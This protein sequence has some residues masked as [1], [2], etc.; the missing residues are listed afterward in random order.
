DK[1]SADMTAPQKE[2]LYVRSEQMLQAYEGFCRTTPGYLN[3]S[4]HPEQS[5][6]GRENILKR[7]L[8][9]RTSQ[10]ELLQAK[11]QRIGCSRKEWQN[12]LSSEGMEGDKGLWKTSK[13]SKASGR[14]QTMA[15]ILAEYIL[16]SP[17]VFHLR[18]SFSIEK[19]LSVIL[20]LLRRRGSRIILDICVMILYF[21]K[22]PGRFYGSGLLAYIVQ[23]QRAIS[24]LL[25]HL[26]H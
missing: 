1:L 23:G 19:G 24:S 3:L 16:T 5:G 15:N 4:D 17:E 2:A 11:G 7:P 22:T 9:K 10:M 8:W 25:P 21:L 14:Y 6:I 13:F 26:S 20:N 12:G 18:Y